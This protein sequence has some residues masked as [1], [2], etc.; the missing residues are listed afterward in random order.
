MQLR[1][2]KCPWEDR[3]G[4]EQAMWYGKLPR[5]DGAVRYGKPPREHGA[6]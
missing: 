3:D 6:M 4:Q 1:A 2:M 5:E